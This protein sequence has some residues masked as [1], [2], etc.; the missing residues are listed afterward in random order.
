[1]AIKD[2]IIKASDVGEAAMEKVLRPYIRFTESGEISPEDAFWE[3]KSDKKIAVALIAADCRRFIGN[4]NDF[5]GGM[6][7]DEIERTA[8]LPGNT[9]R[10]LIKKF[11][12]QGLVR[13]EKGLHYST[14]KLVYWYQKLESKT[15][16]IV[17][18][19]QDSS[20]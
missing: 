7:N 20:L 9:V 1:M 17:R 14:P 8:Q 3:L 2:L 11:R 18:F 19:E 10:P 12:D 6:K 5:I 15:Q 13:T 16:K 4:G